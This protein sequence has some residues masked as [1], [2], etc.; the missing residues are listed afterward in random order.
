[1]QRLARLGAFFPSFLPDPQLKD[2]LMQPLEAKIPIATPP[3]ALALKVRGNQVERLIEKILKSKNRD[4][5][6][7]KERIL[8]QLEGLFDQR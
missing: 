3:S 1:M 7:R 4:L 5:G 2:L 8:S 6:L